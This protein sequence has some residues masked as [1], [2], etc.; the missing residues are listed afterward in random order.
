[1]TVKLIVSTLVGG[2]LL[3]AWQSLSWTVLPIHK[4][5]FKYSPK[6]DTIIDA[7][8]ANLTEAGLYYMPNIDPDQA[9]PEAMQ[10]LEKAS[11]GKPVA[12]VNYIPSYASNM[13][14]AI[15]MGLIYSL[16]VALIVSLVQANMSGLGL[17]GRWLATLG[18]GLVLI[19]FDSMGDLNWFYYP[20]HY[21]Q[22]EILDYLVSF[23]LAGIWFGWYWNRSGARA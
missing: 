20:M 2:I 22:G 3:F 12:M 21:V 4:H 18:F 11:Q 7:L 16:L 1:M 14:K 23:G 13:G 8:S 15:L 9:D 6:Q 19:I 17:A 5:S 10:E